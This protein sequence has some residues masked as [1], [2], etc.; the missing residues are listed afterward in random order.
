M[1]KEKCKR[2]ESLQGKLKE[3]QRQADDEFES[4]IDSYMEPD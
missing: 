1:N 2:I 4:G 3:L